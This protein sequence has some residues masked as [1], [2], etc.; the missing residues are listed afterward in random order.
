MADYAHYNRVWL[1]V[2]KQ[3][4]SRNLPAHAAIFGKTVPE[5]EALGY[6]PLLLTKLMRG[7][8]P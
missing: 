4:P 1:R 6:C 3:T 5:R 8:R 7:P 2:L